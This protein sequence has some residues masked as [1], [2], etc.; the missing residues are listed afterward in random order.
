MPHNLHIWNQRFLAGD[1]EVTFPF[2][3]ERQQARNKQQKPKL[4]AFGNLIATRTDVLLAGEGFYAKPSYA[5][6]VDAQFAFDLDQQ[7]DIA[8]AEAMIAAGM[9]GLKHLELATV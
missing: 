7:A 5:L 4:Y 6:P 2:E 9:V 1:G 8:T 3:A